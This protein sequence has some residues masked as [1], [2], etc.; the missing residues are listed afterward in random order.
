M[1]STYKY[2][3]VYCFGCF[4]HAIYWGIVKKTLR[5]VRVRTVHINTVM[6][7]ALAATVHTCYLQGNCQENPGACTYSTYKYWYVYCLGCYIDAI[8]RGFVIK[9]LRHV[10]TVH[11]NTRMSTALATTY[12]LCSIRGICQE[13]PEAFTNSTYLLYD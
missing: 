8:S 11:I 9:I 3:Y 4:I 10:R 7:T 5:H 12:M 1:Y 13:N 6:C 2:W